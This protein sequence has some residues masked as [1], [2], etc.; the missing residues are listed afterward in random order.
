MK[1]KYS[2]IIRDILFLALLWGYGLYRLI[3]KNDEIMVIIMPLFTYYL[4]R[5]QK[6]NT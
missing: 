6:Q 5:K 1:A 3:L 2:V 4:F